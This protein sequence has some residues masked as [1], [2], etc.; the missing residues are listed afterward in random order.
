MAHTPRWIVVG[1][2]VVLGVGC[3]GP[4]RGSRSGVPA[5]PRAPVIVISVDTLRADRLPMYGYETG[6]TPAL[7]ALRRDGVLFTNAYSHI[8]LT[9]PS[10]T[11]LFTGRLPYEHGVRDNFG[12]RVLKGDF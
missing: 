12:N 6:R 4:D 9:L 2:V 1:L 7:D 10:H 8:P 5:S 11:S 3:E